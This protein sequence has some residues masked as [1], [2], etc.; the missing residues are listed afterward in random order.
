MK[1]SLH[2]KRNPWQSP[3]RDCNYSSSH[4]A[5]RLKIKYDFLKLFEELG[6]PFR[7]F[8]MEDTEHPGD[9]LKLEGFQ[10]TFLRLFRR[11]EPI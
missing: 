4:R 5:S 9:H 10:F 6:E 11:V 1:A 2:E 3:A 8:S 7:S